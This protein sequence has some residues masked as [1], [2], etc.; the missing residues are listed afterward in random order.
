[1]NYEDINCIRL[2]V[3]IILKL[4]L[5]SVWF[6]LTRSRLNAHAQSSSSLPTSSAKQYVLIHCCSELVHSDTFMIIL[7][8][9]VTV[10]D[11]IC[12]DK[13]SHFV[14]VCRFL[15]SCLAID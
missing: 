5:Q 1:M 11:E 8:D 12:V 7:C 4:L 13:C 10:I 6:C 9:G 3:Y 14:K 15:L 2:A